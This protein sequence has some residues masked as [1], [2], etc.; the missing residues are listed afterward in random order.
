VDKESTKQRILKASLVVELQT[1][2]WRFGAVIEL[3]R[4]V[5]HFLD[6]LRLNSPIHSKQEEWTL[7][8]VVW[9]IQQR[10]CN[11][12]LSE[13]AAA[14]LEIGYKGIVQEPKINEENEENEEFEVIE[15][16]SREYEDSD[17]D[18]SSY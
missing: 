12:E 17:P 4:D 1:E 8:D 6:E 13:S 18:L 5:G 3:L 7:Q 11:E 15:V 14:H 9:R 10:L 2:M 16:G